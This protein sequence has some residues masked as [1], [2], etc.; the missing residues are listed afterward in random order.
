MEDQSVQRAVVR[1]LEAIFE[2]DVPACSHGFRKGHRPHHAWHEVREQ[3]RTWPSNGRVDAEVRGF[4]DHVAWSPRRE[5]LQQRGSAGGLL[6]L[7]GKW[8]HAG[9]LEA[10]ARR[11]PDQGTP[12]G[13]GVSP[14]FA[15]VC[16]QHVLDAWCVQDVY[17]R[18]Q[19]HGV[20][21]RFA[22]DGII[23]CEREADAH[24]MMDVLPKRFLRCRLTM[25][26]EKTALMACKRPPRRDPSAG[27]TGPCDVLGLT[28]SWGKT[29]QGYWVIKRQT[30]GKRRRRCRQESGA[31]CREH[32]PAPLHE[33]SRT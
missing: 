12:P 21:T 13:G 31:W 18:R 32:R 22:E 9:V 2:P 16:L 6:R 17:P 27:G 25:P 33:P 23:G 8:L 5:L 29:R 11:H 7:M 4:F 3:C 14:L 26:P 19:G 28:H 1:I 24:R 15:H 20:L 30:I 10:G